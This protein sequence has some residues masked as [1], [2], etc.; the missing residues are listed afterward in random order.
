[1]LFFQ[2]FLNGLWDFFGI[3]LLILKMNFWKTKIGIILLNVIIIYDD[4]SPL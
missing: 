1:M 3:M 2:Y 4:A